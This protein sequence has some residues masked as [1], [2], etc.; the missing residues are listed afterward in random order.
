VPPQDSEQAKWF[1]THIQP[2]E[3]VLRAWLR[4]RFP[5]GD[6]DIEDVLQDSY[7]RVLQAHA[8]GNLQ[9][10]K[11][12]LFATA[13]NLV[14]DRL[15]H[16]RVLRTDSLVES[17]ALNVLDEEGDV[18]GAVARSQELAH[19]TE[20]IQLL[21][22]RCRQIFTL[23]KIYGMPQKEI[24]KKLGISE[25]T[26]SAQLTIGIHRCTDYFARY[27]RERGGRP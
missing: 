16:S 27:R 15:R 13:R 22:D 19:L 24:A 7:I 26:V 18:A 23:R 6:C 8:S 2:H 4:N 5:D 21:P 14:L 10:P 20:V 9:F 3:P 1:A 11:A 25:H 17:E 12:F